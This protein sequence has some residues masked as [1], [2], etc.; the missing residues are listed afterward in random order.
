MGNRGVIL[1]EIYLKT[2][3]TVSEQH[4]KVCIWGRWGVKK[5]LHIAGE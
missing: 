3:Q 2:Q 1:N 4:L 5:K